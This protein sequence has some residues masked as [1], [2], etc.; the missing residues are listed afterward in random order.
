MNRLKNKSGYKLLAFSRKLL[1]GMLWL[2]A[3]SLLLMA[4]TSHQH[5]DKKIFHYN[6]S[7]GLASLDPAFAKNKQVMWSTHQLYNTLIEI[8]S[9]MQMQPSLAK[10]WTISDDNLIF[11][12]TIRNDVFFTDDDCF[13]NGK[14]RKLTAHYV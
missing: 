8:D 13:T 14:G 5:P 6:E 9:S 11:T 10:H 4:C 1:A 3:N 7:S 12:F 2:M